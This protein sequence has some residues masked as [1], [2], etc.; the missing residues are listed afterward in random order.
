MDQFGYSLK[1]PYLK[2]M[3]N[4]E[5]LLGPTKKNEKNEWAW[6]TRADVDK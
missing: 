1:L 2:I 6:N 4:F 3:A 5:K